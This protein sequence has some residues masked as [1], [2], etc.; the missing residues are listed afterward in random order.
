[1]EEETREGEEYRDREQKRG[2]QGGSRTTPWRRA[3]NEV[4][5]D[6]VE[7]QGPPG[8]GE[9]GGGKRPREREGRESR[10]DRRRRGR[11]AG[12][13]VDQWGP[14]Q[15]TRGGHEEAGRTRKQRGRG[16]PGEGEGAEGEQGGRGTGGVRERRRA[17]AARGRKGNGW[18]GGRG[19][20]RG[21][22]AGGGGPRTGRG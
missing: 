10:A 19:T 21:T 9:Q 14:P 2:G 6:R 13:E 7:K 20:G 8:C 3:G 22:S 1:M 12:G 5:K 11:S 16:G 4:E 15:Q 17:A 18:W